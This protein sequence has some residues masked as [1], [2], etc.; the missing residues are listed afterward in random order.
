ML[1]NH[2]IQKYLYF[3]NKHGSALEGVEGKDEDQYLEKNFNEFP[4]IDLGEDG[5]IEKLEE[6]YDP[7][8]LKNR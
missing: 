6:I 3:E 1:L 8:Y 5:L 2:S 7:T 4:T